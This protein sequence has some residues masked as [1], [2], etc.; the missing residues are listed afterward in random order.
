MQVFTIFYQ[1]AGVVLAGAGLGT[2]VRKVIELQQK[3][4][5]K[6]SLQLMKGMEIHDCNPRL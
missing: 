3:Y 4:T 2:I 5:K 6:M 1:F